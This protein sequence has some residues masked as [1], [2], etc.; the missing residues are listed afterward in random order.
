MSVV[1]PSRRG[2]RRRHQALEVHHQHHQRSVTITDA[3]MIE[4][5]ELGAR[6]ARNQRDRDGTVRCSSTA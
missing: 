3:A 4:P 1:S 6:S 2:V 5:M